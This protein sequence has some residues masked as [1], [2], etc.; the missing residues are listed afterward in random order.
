[1]H[2]TSRSKLDLPGE[3]E[4]HSGNGFVGDE[5]NSYPQIAGSILLLPDL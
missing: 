4:T 1:M 5:T 3:I 2:I